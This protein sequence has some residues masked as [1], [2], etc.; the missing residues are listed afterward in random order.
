[1]RKSTAPFF[2]LLVL[3]FFGLIAVVSSCNNAAPEEETTG[4]VA[5]VVCSES[6]S[7]IG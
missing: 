1:M 7:V 6:L 3:V 2:A 4:Q 5:Q